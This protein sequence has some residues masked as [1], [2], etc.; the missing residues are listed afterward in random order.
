MYMCVYIYIARDRL[1]EELYRLFTDTQIS[2]TYIYI[3]VYINIYICNL[4]GNI[5]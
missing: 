1:K 3:Y 2:H 5:Y 4:R